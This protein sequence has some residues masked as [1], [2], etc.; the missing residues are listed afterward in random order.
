[1]CLGKGM[2]MKQASVLTVLTRG[3]DPER[4]IKYYTTHTHTHTDT[5]PCTRWVREKK[6]I[7]QS[8]QLRRQNPSGTNWTLGPFTAPIFC[9]LLQNHTNVFV[10]FL[11]YFFSAFI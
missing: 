2:N 7:A 6:R 10:V 1:M 5:C 3:R 4:T 8:S 11:I 9:F